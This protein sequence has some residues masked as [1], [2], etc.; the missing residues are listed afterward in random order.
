MLVT[1]QKRPELPEKQALL[2]PNRSARP[3][4]VVPCDVGGSTARSPATRPDEG[5]PAR[6]PLLLIRDL[7]RGMHLFRCNASSVEMLVP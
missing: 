3:Q 4:A 1:A 6:S 2:L 5:R 7:S